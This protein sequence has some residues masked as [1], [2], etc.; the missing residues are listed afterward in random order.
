MQH[1]AYLYEGSQDHLSALAT[2]AGEYFGIAREANPDLH[3]VSW[4]K[5]GI[6]EA[7]ELRQQASLRGVST[8]SLFV[9]GIASITTEAQQALLKLF[10]EP[11]KGVIFV[12]LVPHGVLLPTLRS[13]FL[14]WPQQNFPSAHLGS[15]PDNKAGSQRER[16]EN[17]AEAFMRAPSKDRS[18]QIALLLKDEEN[19]K[20]RIRSFLDA[21]EAKLYAQLNV[22]PRRSNTKEV[23]EGLEDI[24]KVRSYVGDRSPSFKMLLEHLATA[25]PRFDLNS[26]STRSN[27]VN[28]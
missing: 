2:A 23:R 28:P 6:N 19:I 1:H 13:R 27:L 17:S 25:L 22:R 8:R 26:G 24:A 7:R 5:F 9:L 10:E 18:A 21:L 15:L 14:A 3:I 20:E 11:A 16:P 12:L 4:E